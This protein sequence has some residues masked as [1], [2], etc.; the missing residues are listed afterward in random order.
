MTE[1]SPTAQAA[2][3]E[4]A[5]AVKK[6]GLAEKKRAALSQMLQARGSAFP[7]RSAATAAKRLTPLRAVR[8]A[9]AHREQGGGD[10][11][12]RGAASQ[13]DRSV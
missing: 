8:A 12:R 2:R 7:R 1:V 13:R 9:G 5:T 11:G 10:G 6:A 4:A 3:E